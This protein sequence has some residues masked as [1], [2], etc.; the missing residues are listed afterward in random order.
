V[1][2]TSTPELN[3]ST[4]YVTN[5][6]VSDWANARRV[7]EDGDRLEIVRLRPNSDS[8]RV[9]AAP[10]SFVVGLQ[11]GGEH[12]AGAVGGV[13]LVRRDVGGARSNADS[14][15]DIGAFAFWMKN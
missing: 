5:D 7:V 11:A 3:F 8:D 6:A 15:I 2:I 1:I 10:E 4:N 12:R 9:H 13:D 14:A